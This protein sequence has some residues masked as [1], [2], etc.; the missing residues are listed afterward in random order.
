VRTGLLL[1]LALAAAIGTGCSSEEPEGSSPTTSSSSSSAAATASASPAGELDVE[2]SRAA[3]EAVG[4][5]ED[6]VFDGGQFDYDRP[7][8]RGQLAADGHLSAVS[9]DNYFVLDNGQVGAWGAGMD[10]W[11]TPR[12][13]RVAAKREAFFFGCPGPR[14]LIAL[15][16]TGDRFQAATSCRKPAND[17]WRATAAAS[18]GVVS[19]NLTVA[20]RTRALTERGLVAAWASLTATSDEVRALLP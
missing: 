15:P 7:L 3:L 6:G 11:E 8:L 18:N 12:A 19:R 13:A 14:H 17:G 20:A 2:S 16:D 4:S 10:V 5:P 9:W 1:S